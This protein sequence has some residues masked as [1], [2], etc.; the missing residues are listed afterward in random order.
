MGTHYL[1]DKHGCRLE[2]TDSTIDVRI[3]FRGSV[4]IPLHSVIAV[5][6]ARWR[7]TRVIQIQTPQGVYEWALGDRAMEAARA[8]ADAAGVALMPESMV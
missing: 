2:V 1:V 3:R 7:S 8:V 4:S 5:G 6:T